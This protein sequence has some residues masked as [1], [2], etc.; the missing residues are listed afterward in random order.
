[1]YCVLYTRTCYVQKEKV[2]FL[3]YMLAKVCFLSYML[4]KVFAKA[5]FLFVCTC[6][7]LYT[8][9]KNDKS[10][11]QVQ[12]YIYKFSREFCSEKFI[13]KQGF[14]FATLLLLPL[15]TVLSIILG[16]TVH[17]PIAA[18]SILL[19]FKIIISPTVQCTLYIVQ[20][21]VGMIQLH[22]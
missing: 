19:F 22:G 4:A 9:K 20:Y 11:Y 8:F 7:D 15:I 5:R 18:V 10:Y 21:T 1:M 13:F 17:L 6:L 3:S 14:I 16:P 2:C 12:I